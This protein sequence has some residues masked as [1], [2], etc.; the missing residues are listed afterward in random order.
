MMRPD[1]SSY[2]LWDQIPYTPAMLYA[3]PDILGRDFQAG[4]VQWE[5]FPWVFTVQKVNLL[6]K[7]VLLLMFA[8]G[9]QDAAVR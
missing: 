3:V 2:F 9:S 7:P 8:V 4:G 6:E 5:K 1:I